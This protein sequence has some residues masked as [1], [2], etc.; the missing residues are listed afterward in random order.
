MAI[1][2]SPTICRTIVIQLL[3]AV[4]ENTFPNRR[5]GHRYAP[6]H[7]DQDDEH[8]MNCPR[9]GLAPPVPPLV[10]LRS[11][12]FFTPYRPTRT[13]QDLPCTSAREP[14]NLSLVAR[15]CP[16]RARSDSHPGYLTATKR[17]VAIPVELRKGSL[18]RTG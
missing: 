17:Q 15:P 4:I 12:R 14:R 8:V 18:V 6:R 10:W 13:R 1:T 3:R 7:Q 5:R 9:G 11:P 16:L 2:T